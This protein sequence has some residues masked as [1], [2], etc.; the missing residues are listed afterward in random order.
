MAASCVACMHSITISIFTYDELARRGWAPFAI[1]A[2]FNLASANTPTG[3][4]AMVF[5]NAYMVRIN[6]TTFRM[7]DDCNNKYFVRTASQ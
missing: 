6:K 4:A 2:D 1:T 7:W 3:M 5:T